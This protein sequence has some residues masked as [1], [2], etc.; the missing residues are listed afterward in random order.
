MDKTRKIRLA[1]YRDKSFQNVNI[2]IIK[3]YK[4]V[5]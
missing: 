5:I 2:I 1:F 4:G 3:K